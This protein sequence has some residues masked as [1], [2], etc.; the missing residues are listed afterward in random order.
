MRRREFIAGLGSTAVAWPLAARAQRP[1]MPLVGLLNGVSFEGAYEVPVAAIR[2]G[3]RETGFIEGQNVAIEYRHAGGRYE[4]LPELATDLFR[5]Q[6]AVIVA[7][8]PAT[9]ALAAA[10]ATSTIPIVFATGSDAIQVD[11]VNSLR[12]PQASLTGVNPAATELASKRLELLLELRPGATLVGYLDN[13]RLSGAFET[14]VEGLTAAA[15]IKGRELV[16]FDAATE[17]EVETAFTDIALQRVRLLVV[18]PDAF[19]NTRQEQI[20][21]LAAQSGLPTIYATRG[22][23]V[24]GGLM[25]YGVPTDLTNDMYRL[26]GIYAGRILNGAAPA[27][28]PVMHST[29]FELVINNKTAKALRITVPRRLLSRADEIIG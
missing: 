28:S 10:A 8:G 3:L 9:P 13:S 29:R 15:R 20:V 6:V 24:L 11:L 12:R 7:I 23:V 25:S 27:E 5:R 4:R 17:P 26:A 2:R 19:L 21:A 18:S 14:N 22:A 1:E 16:V